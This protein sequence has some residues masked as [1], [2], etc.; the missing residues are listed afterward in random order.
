MMGNLNCCSTGMCLSIFSI[1][2]SQAGCLPFTETGFFSLAVPFHPLTSPSS[3]PVFVHFSGL[4]HWNFLGKL[5]SENR[6]ISECQFRT[7]SCREQTQVT[8]HTVVPGSGVSWCNPGNT[9]EGNELLVTSSQW[10]WQ[11]RRGTASSRNVAAFRRRNNGRYRGVL[12]G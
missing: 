7:Q 1:L 12:M 4:F 5:P 2:F 8:R 3:M 10:R 11:H 9:F 6:T